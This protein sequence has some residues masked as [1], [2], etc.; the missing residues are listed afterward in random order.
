MNHVQIRFLEAF[1]ILLFRGNRLFGEPGS[2]GESLMPPWPSQVA[3]AL[4]SR[5]LVE[6]K[7]DLNSFA[8][9]RIRHRELGTPEEPGP[10]TLTLCSLARRFAD[11]RTELL[12][13]PPAD[14]VIEAAK[15]EAVPAPNSST[16]PRLNLAVN[17]LRPK[18]FDGAPPGWDCS[19]ELSSLP[20]LPQDKRSKPSPGWWFTE[21]GWKKYLAGRRSWD[22]AQD[23]IPVASLWQ[24]E[25]RVG[26]GLSRETRAAAEGRLF[27][28]RAVAFRKQEHGS[29][30]GAHFDVGL[31]VAY[32]GAAPGSLKDGALL[33]LGGDNR[34]AVVNE[35]KEYKLP[36]VDYGRLCDAR[37]CRMILASPGIFTEG[38]LPE[39]CRKDGSSII[40]EL[41]GVEARLVAAAVSR[42]QVVS[43]WDLA[44]WLP[45][46]AC[47]AAA[48]GSVYWLEELKATSADLERLVRWGLWTQPEAP[49]PRRAEGFNRIWLAEWPE[50]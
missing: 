5:L 16:G 1:D 33:R 34:A 24:S 35:V 44:R 27:S 42:F 37:R 9:G 19:Y 2:F 4:R 36:S 14:V 7:E 32:T 22:P 15:A 25:T 12:V 10:F 29:R 13:P 39:G 47:R 20:V 8:A 48:P 23:L 3:G 6:S 28:N 41:H 17:Q 38:W 50:E 40:F 43:G 46:A 30:D 49:E 11:G 45:K 26:V 21:S 31:L 18:I